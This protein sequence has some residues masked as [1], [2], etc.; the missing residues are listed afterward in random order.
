MKTSVVLCGLFTLIGMLALITAGT[1]MLWFGIFGG[2]PTNLEQYHQLAI[3]GI[4]YSGIGLFLAK[5]T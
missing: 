1:M 5:M 3:G 2:D 4:C